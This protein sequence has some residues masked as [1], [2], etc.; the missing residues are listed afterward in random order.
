M[1]RGEL[2]EHREA[3]FAIRISFV[4]LSNSQRITRQ[5]QLNGN[6]LI[7]FKRGRCFFEGFAGFVFL[8]GVELKSRQYRPGLGG[9]RR[10]LIASR[11]ACMASSR[12]F[13][14]LRWSTTCN[15]ADN[16]ARRTPWS[17]DEGSRW[18]R[19]DLSGELR[20]AP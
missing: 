20:S 5:R 19:R 6:R 12:L 2:A 8:P 13:C 18:Q 10:L 1:I 17:P 14:E 4:A 11:Q 9:I 15:A 7:S 16:K 3:S